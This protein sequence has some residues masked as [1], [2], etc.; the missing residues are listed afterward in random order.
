[1]AAFKLRR[2]RKRK[3]SILVKKPRFLILK[4]DSESFILTGNVFT[5]K[6]YVEQGF[7]VVMEARPA[8]TTQDSPE[9]IITT[10]IKEMVPVNCERC[11]VKTDEQIYH[12]VDW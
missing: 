9:K 4:S 10:G 1:M 6:D 7:T 2:R 11:I 3:E 5:A 8:K 12:I